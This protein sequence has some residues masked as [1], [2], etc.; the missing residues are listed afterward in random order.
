MTTAGNVLV[1]L[2]AIVTAYG[3]SVLWWQ[4]SDTPQKWRAGLRNLIAKV[5]RWARFG[6]PVVHTAEAHL[7]VVPTMTATGRI[8]TPRVSVMTEAERLAHLYE[9]IDALAEQHAVTRAEDLK[10]NADL[11][12]QE[13]NDYRAKQ[14]AETRCQAV[15][16]GIG[17]AL[18]IVGTVL[19]LLA[20]G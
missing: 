17:V 12:K 20:G 14:R 18:T 1:L 15:I 13:V 3:V 5:K 6:R 16:A 7:I 2:G 19:M 8:G 9:R 4:N 11:I 10:H